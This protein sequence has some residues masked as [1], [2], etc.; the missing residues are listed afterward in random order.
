MNVAGTGL[1]TLFWSWHCPPP[2]PNMTANFILTG[3]LNVGW[4][5][6]LVRDHPD[7]LT[8]SIPLI[9]KVILK[10]CNPLTYLIF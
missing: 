9:F 6:A 7:G 4:L 2:A 3:E 10:I 8:K 1:M 5:L